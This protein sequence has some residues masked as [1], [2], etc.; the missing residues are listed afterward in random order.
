MSHLL[1]H[2]RVCLASLSIFIYNCYLAQAKWLDSRAEL[3]ADWGQAI[4]KLPWY[5]AMSEAPRTWGLEHLL[6]VEDRMESVSLPPV[7][8]VQ[9]ALCLDF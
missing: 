3:Q 6:G 4:L 2:P 1:I 8:S 7:C 5:L 9:K